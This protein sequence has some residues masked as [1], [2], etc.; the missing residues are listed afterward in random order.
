MLASSNNDLTSTLHIKNI[1][2]ISVLFKDTSIQRMPLYLYTEDTF[3]GPYVSFTEHPHPARE[4][5]QF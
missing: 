4:I 1:P 5:E 2:L 3:Q